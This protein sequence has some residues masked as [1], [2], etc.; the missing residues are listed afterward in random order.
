MPISDLPFELLSEITDHLVTSYS[1]GSLANLN[2][3]SRHFRDT[4]ISNLY[5]TLILLKMDP[6]VKVEEEYNPPIRVGD[7]IPEG[8][9]H[10]R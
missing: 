1:H 3:T 7:S 6:Q 4:T 5:R 9:E 2:Q 10:T 8:W